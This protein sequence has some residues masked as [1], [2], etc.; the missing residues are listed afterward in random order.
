MTWST[1][2]STRHGEN[3]GINGIF[4]TPTFPRLVGSASA[5]MASFQSLPNELVVSIIRTLSDDRKIDYFDPVGI[6][7]LQHVRL[8]CRRMSTLAAPLLFE[9]MILDEKLLD[10][11]DLTRLSR[12]A[13]KN[14]L[15]AGHVRRLRRRL[16]PLIV[17]GQHLGRKYAEQAELAGLDVTSLLGCDNESRLLDSLQGQFDIKSAFTE[18]R[19]CCHV[20][21]SSPQDLPLSVSL[22]ALNLLG[23]RDT[24]N[25]SSEKSYFL[26]TYDQGLS[27]PVSLGKYSVGTLTPAFGGPRKTMWCKL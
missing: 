15:L 20:N 6:Q 3:K 25:F 18:V 26:S 24:D 19:P 13:K 14:P 1:C 5:K 2:R 16:S 8:S 12:F 10:E 23:K 7:D 17:S 4:K 9:N 27:K 21:L 11:E 22:P